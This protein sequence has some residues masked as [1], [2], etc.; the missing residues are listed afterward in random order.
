MEYPKN[1]AEQEYDELHSLCDELKNSKISTENVER[2]IFVLRD[3]R[4]LATDKD[5]QVLM[6]VSQ[7]LML[8]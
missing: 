5:Y 4:L 6:Q 7:C 3:L 1:K 2:L 8:F